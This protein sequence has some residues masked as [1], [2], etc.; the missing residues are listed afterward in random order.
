MWSSVRSVCSSVLRF[1]AGLEAFFVPQVL[2]EDLGLVLSAPEA[3]LVLEPD[4]SEPAEMCLLWSAEPSSIS[5]VLVARVGP[6]G[7]FWDT[8]WVPSVLAVVPRE[9]QGSAGTS[10]W[11][12]GAVCLFLSFL[13]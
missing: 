9:L 1:C 5:S 8:W 11:S 7:E 2:E 10:H 4:F 12:H 3:V 13:W 6:Q